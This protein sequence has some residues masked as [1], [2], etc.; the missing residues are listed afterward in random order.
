MNTPPEPAPETRAMT[1][2]E[3]ALRFELFLRSKYPAYSQE[4]RDD[5]QFLLN[6]FD[7]IL[8]PHPSPACAE[9]A[10]R[11]DNLGSV[12]L[13]L[14]STEDASAKGNPAGRSLFSNLA[15][16]LAHEINKI[17]AQGPWSE[18]QNPD[19]YIAS[20]IL[21]HCSARL[22]PALQGGEANEQFFHCNGC[23][24]SFPCW[25]TGAA[26]H[27]PECIEKLPPP[28]TPYPPQPLREVIERVV[29][30]TDL[31]D[32]NSA[33]LTDRLLSA[34]TPLLAPSA[35]NENAVEQARADKVLGT[36][37]YRDAKPG[38]FG[39]S[40]W[41]DLLMACQDGRA[42]CMRVLEIIERE[43][44]PVAIAEGDKAKV[45]A[46]AFLR[47]PLPESVCADLCATKQQAGR[48]GTNLLSFVE[49]EQMMREVVLPLLAH[50][51]RSD[52]ER[53]DKENNRSGGLAWVCKTLAEMASMEHERPSHKRLLQGLS[54]EVSEILTN[55]G[56][57]MIASK[58]AKHFAKGWTAEHDDKHTHAEIAINAA[59]LI[60]MGTDAE[61]TIHSDCPDWGL[62]A[63]HEGDR[64]DRLA[65]AGSLIAAE[66]DRLQRAALAAQ[67]EGKK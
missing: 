24:P 53:S 31:T 21:R 41:L 40:E 61:V 50:D 10:A 7:A 32:C 48:I 59:L 9:A 47:W 2:A 43:T 8:G 18:T 57:G 33:V 67:T 15:K 51:K 62:D 22:A 3:S 46:D 58:R 56:V 28:T 63:L 60:V 39:R 54:D 16:K 30:A 49:A 19:D 55:S 1:D 14:T 52:G 6:K 34:L 36:G 45:L 37:F 38:T 29:D 25:S 42:T 27:H 66:I 13:P 35:V 23:D 64:I 4:Q 5:A 12:L 44:V 26:C 65:V 17:H 20:I 11:G